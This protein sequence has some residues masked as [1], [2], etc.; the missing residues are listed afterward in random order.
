MRVFRELWR[1]QKFLRKFSWSLYNLRSTIRRMALPLLV[2]NY[3]KIDSGIPTKNLPTAL[4]ILGWG[5][6]MFAVASAI[7]THRY[8][9]QLNQLF[10]NNYY[11]ITKL[12]WTLKKIKLNYSLL[13]SKV[14]RGNTIEDFL[15]IIPVK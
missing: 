5:W 10:Q 6:L 4:I 12:L 8:A 13:N 7:S 2:I 15:K 14:L 9:L 1:D 11:T 3:S